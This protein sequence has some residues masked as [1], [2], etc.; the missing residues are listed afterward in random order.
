MVLAVQR[1]T[2]F[3]PS[4]PSAGAT[5]RARDDRLLDLF[6]DP[7]ASVGDVHDRLA[8]A[9]VHLR[10]QS[11][12]RSVFL[13]IYTA[14]TGQ[15][16]DGIDAGTFDDPA[17]VRQYLVAFAERYRTALL[18]F[19]RGDDG[20]SLPWQLAFGASTGGGTLL[21][22]D[23]LLGINAHI[24]GDLPFALRD[25][26]L[27]PDRAAKRRDHDRI[28]RILERLVDVAQ[29]ALVE[30]YGARGYERVDAALGSVDEE[31]TLLGLQTARTVAWEHA[32]FL[33]D[34]DAALLRRLV[35]WRVHAVATGAGLFVLAPGADPTKLAVLREIER[36]DPPIGALFD[37]FDRR[38]TA[39]GSEPI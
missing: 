24:N 3:G 21:V 34:V 20:L 11:D 32:V 28:N 22:Q 8:A 17:W 23:A 36:G 10:E 7:F 4:I 1:T 13:T 38:V 9:A 16:G 15:V 31:F 5:D 29:A 37:A 30:V 35:R 39:T 2:P 25:V 33:T 6:A 18:A 27:D 19:E 14:M 12:R 26:S